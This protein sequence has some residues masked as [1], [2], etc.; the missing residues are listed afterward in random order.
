MKNEIS[1]KHK[2]LEGLMESY[3]RIQC[4]GSTLNF[5]FNVHV[6]NGRSLTCCNRF[7]NASWRFQS[8]RNEQTRSSHHWIIQNTFHKTPATL[9]GTQFNLLNS[10][11]S[12][13]NKKIHQ[14]FFVDE[15]ATFKCCITREDEMK[16]KEKL[17]KIP[18]IYLWKTSI[19]KLKLSC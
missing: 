17:E 12:K 3:V 5:W 2:S 1:R 19:N 6:V 7:S 13:Q 15:R 16:I 18:K 11:T 8:P 9:A 14:K 10:K 4:L